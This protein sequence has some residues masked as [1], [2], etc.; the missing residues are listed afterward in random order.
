MQFSVFLMR[1]FRL[2]LLLVLLPLP[3]LADSFNAAFSEQQRAVSE[4][5]DSQKRVEQLDDESR[6]LL[7][8]YRQVTAEL[9][10]LEQ[11]NEH[12]Q[13]FIAS[14]D[15]ELH[16]LAEQLL[17]IDNT[18]REIEPLMGRMLEVLDRFVELDTPFLPDE[19]A[20]RIAQLQDL[21]GQSDTTLPERYR[22]LLEAYQV[23]T[24]YGR[25]IESYRGKL[26]L[27]GEP[28]LVTFLRLGRVA[29]YYLTLDGK[30]A[31]IWNRA[32]TRWEPL[33]L[34]HNLKIDRALQIAEKR[35][36]PDLMPLPLSVPERMQ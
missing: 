17:S 14:Q 34:E 25:T 19:R 18:R 8:N 33:G 22:R 36:P 1:L 11:Y 4:A 26:E 6:N 12:R 32:L 20:K 35:L 31:G 24:E 21:E 7:E 5:I 30:A 3:V 2:V 9:E 29:L 27:D 16:R 28:R 23:E 15:E 13:R 10:R